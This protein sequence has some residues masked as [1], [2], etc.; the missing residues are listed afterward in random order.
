MNWL[1]L[2]KND[3]SPVVRLYVASAAQRI[4]VSKRLPILEGLFAHA[5]DVA[6]HNLPLMY[7]YAAS[8]WSAPIS[9]PRRNC[10]VKRRFPSSASS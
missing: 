2:A 9:S 6:D 3:A 7:W 4:A 5:E 8:H 10:S 1:A